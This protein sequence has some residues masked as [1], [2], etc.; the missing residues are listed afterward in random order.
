M[1]LI[2]ENDSGLLTP[3]CQMDVWLLPVLCSSFFPEVSPL[4]ST[5]ALPWALRLLSLSREAQW[6]W[7]SSSV[8][9]RG[10]DFYYQPLMHTL[11]SFF[12][13]QWGVGCEVFML[14]D[15]HRNEHLCQSSHRCLSMIHGFAH[16]SGR[17]W[18]SLPH[19]HANQHTDLVWEQCRHGGTVVVQQCCII[20]APYSRGYL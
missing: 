13:S 15:M 1:N 8:Q 12:F 20:M 7:P 17:S 2:I 9:W 5:A 6:L 18:D 16:R 10:T 11:S 3:L 19:T 4:T 14:R